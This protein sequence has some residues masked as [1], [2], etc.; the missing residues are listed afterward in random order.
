M[1][2][3]YYNLVKSGRRTIRQV[4]VSIRSEVI[5]L[6]EADGITVTT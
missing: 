3:I 4:P 6:L 5:A 2:N 1:V